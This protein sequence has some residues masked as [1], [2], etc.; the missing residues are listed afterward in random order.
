MN[1]ISTTIFV[2]QLCS[3]MCGAQT[4]TAIVENSISEVKKDL[5]ALDNELGVD[6]HLSPEELTELRALTP[7]YGLVLSHLILD[8]KEK[9]NPVDA[10]EFTQKGIQVLIDDSHFQGFP[11]FVLR[12]TLVVD[13][14]LGLNEIPVL[15]RLDFL[16]KSV[17]FAESE[18]SYVSQ[19]ESTIE[20]AMRYFEFLYVFHESIFDS[21]AST[22]VFYR[23]LIFL[24]WDLNLD[25]RRYE[26]AEE[27]ISIYDLVKNIQKNGEEFSN[28]QNWINL[29]FRVLDRLAA[30]G[31]SV[32][33]T[34]L[35][36]V[37]KRFPMGVTVF[38][39]GAD[40]PKKSIARVMDVRSVSEVDV[41]YFLYVDEK[42]TETVRSSQLSPQVR[43]P[44]ESE[45]KNFIRVYQWTKQSF[46][47]LA[48][49]PQ[50]VLFENGLCLLE[51]VKL[52]DQI[53]GVF[54]M[55]SETFYGRIERTDIKQS[56]I[57][58][59]E[60]LTDDSIARFVDLDYEVSKS[61][62][63]NLEVNMLRGFKYFGVVMAAKVKRIF[64]NGLVQLELYRNFPTGLEY[65]HTEWAREEDLIDLPPPSLF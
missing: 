42:K 20:F 45:N 13:Q 15:Q 14:S 47:L 57:N 63:L 25:G 53:S 4:P 41:E 30:K 24:D 10:L 54:F 6:T 9:S 32:N 33:I 21:K 31:F 5:A 38:V 59:S 56:E 48:V 23:S 29:S 16:K 37:K 8:A 35:S 12:R 17:R 7:Q 26:V 34:P 46:P 11:R 27:I 64:T 52:V 60:G 51:R 44:K 49:V 36:K 43:I 65:S 3:L 61:R 50:P 22:E 19:S 18:L 1:K 39:S 58:Y 28:F 55:G 2:L 62:K 40:R